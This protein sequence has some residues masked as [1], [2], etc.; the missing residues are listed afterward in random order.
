MTMPMSPVSSVRNAA[1]FIACHALDVVGTTA[2]QVEACE[3][4][5]DVDRLMGMG[6]KPHRCNV[7]YPSRGKLYRAF[8]QVD[9]FSSCWGEL[10]DYAEERAS[11]GV[12]S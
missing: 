3:S 11:V 2:I 6:F 9:V 10:L 5:D 4:R 1:D 12:T 7:T 8:G